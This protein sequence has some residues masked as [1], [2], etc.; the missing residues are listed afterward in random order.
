M[1]KYMWAG[2][3]LIATML[4][5]CGGLQSFTFDQLYP[6][7]VTFPEQV[8]TVAVVNHA[9]SFPSPKKTLLTLGRLDGD[10]KVFAE[11][12]AGGLADSRYFN[13]VIISDSV[14]TQEKSEGELL[15]R[16]VVDSLSQV[17]GADMIFSVDHIQLLTTKK[18]IYYPGFVPMSALDLKIR[19]IVRAYI[20]SRLMPVMTLNAVDSL[21]WDLDPTLSDYE[22]V[23]DAS[24]HAAYTLVNQ[25]VPHWKNVERFYFDGG[26]PDM[27]DAAVSLREGD[28]QEASRIWKELYDSFKK[29]KQK[30][31]AAFNLALACEVQGKMEDADFWIKE[32]QKNASPGSDEER[33]VAL[34]ATILKGRAKDFQML[35]LQ[36]K[37]FGNNFN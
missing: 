9:P 7:E 33:I 34:Y 24:S 1:K 21:L 26:S 35:N 22:V 6:A 13:Q 15:S 37:R 32:A 25:L 12:L 16:S 3:W 18:E 11:N 4:V 27:R 10:G 28:W 8:R 17:L 19:P 14:L 20:P 36:M 5:S 23:H 31:R 29:G 30:F 2:V